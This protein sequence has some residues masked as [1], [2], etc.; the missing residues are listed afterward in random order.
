MGLLSELRLQKKQTDI[1]PNL[2]RTFEILEGRKLWVG[3]SLFQP[4]DTGHVGR[5]VD[6]WWLDALQISCATHVDR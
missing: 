3:D 5:Y 6:Q 2:E 1:I 4:T